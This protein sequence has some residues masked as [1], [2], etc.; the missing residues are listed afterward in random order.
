M[1]FPS[2]GTQHGLAAWTSFCSLGEPSLLSL[3]L[4]SPRLECSSPR[5]CSWLQPDLGCALREP[6]WSPKADTCQAP[7]TTAPCLLSSLHLF[8]N[9]VDDFFYCGKLRITCDGLLFFLD[10]LYGLRE[11]RFPHQGSNPA[12]RV[13]GWSPNHSVW[14]SGEFPKMDHFKVLPRKSH[15]WRSLVG[16]SPWGCTE[17]D[18]TEAT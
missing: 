3:L 11:S 14:T 16:C 18:T 10:A 4:L 7:S 12:L 2:L 17:S 5:L 15:G 13:K 6:P 1:L 9:D 8:W